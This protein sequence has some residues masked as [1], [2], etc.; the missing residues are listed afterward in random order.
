MMTELFVWIIDLDY[1]V[2]IARKS[3][4][5]TMPNDNAHRFRRMHFKRNTQNRF[6]F[7]S[8]KQLDLCSCPFSIAIYREML[9]RKTALRSTA[10]VS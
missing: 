10:S 6:P 3:T 2:W 9:T 5:G 8:R 1:L 4:I 7:I